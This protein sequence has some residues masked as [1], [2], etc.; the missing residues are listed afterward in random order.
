MPADVDALVRPTLQRSSAEPEQLAA[1][2]GIG[3]FH[4]VWDRSGGL[5]RAILGGPGLLPAALAEALGD[6]VQI[7]SAVSEVVADGDGVRVVHEHGELQARCAVV[8]TPAHVT[9]TVV[10]ELP[11]DTRHAARG[12]ALRP[13][14]RRGVS[15]PRDAR[16]PLGTRST[17]SP[18]PDARSTF[19][20]T[21]RT[22]CET[23]DDRREP[24]GSLMVYAA[25]DLARA[26]WE[27]DDATVTSAFLADLEAIFPGARDLVAETVI[28]R[29]ERGL[30]YVR[31]GRHL[32]QS[33]LLRPLGV[34]F[35]AGDYLG[36]RYTETAIQTGIDAAAAVRHRIAG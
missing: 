32:L 11:E 1:G 27:S 3:Y 16:A 10:R 33:A 22:S 30:P 8:A 6:R 9:R 4:L 13:V 35:L 20:S 25:A 29:W 26:L 12:A 24:G 2:Y 34:V 17:R 14:R 7:R 36:T 21:P 5:G 23:R 18:P 15:H 28:Q 31:P 19:S